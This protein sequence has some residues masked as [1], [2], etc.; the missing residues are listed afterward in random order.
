MLKSQHLNFIKA[1][2]RVSGVSRLW[3]GLIFLAGLGTAGLLHWAAIND[4]INMDHLIGPC[5]FKQKYGLP[6]P[7][8]GMTTALI[9]FAR[10]DILG[11]FY[12]QP[13]AAVVYSV[14]VAAVMF[15]FVIAVLG[16]DFGLINGLCRQLKV[17]Y[18]IFAAIVIV[19][20]GWLVTLAHA[21]AG[22]VP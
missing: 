18:I 22:K 15:A 10:G 19:F 9:A 17:G 13:A 3:A 12:I 16:T 21:L 7:G 6:C 1:S 20:G 8:C 2:Y 4:K 11:A 14:A 5:G